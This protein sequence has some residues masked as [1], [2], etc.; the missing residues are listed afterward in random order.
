MI[1][2]KNGN[3]ETIDLEAIA[4]V[5]MRDN[6][7]WSKWKM[8]RWKK[9]D[10][11]EKKKTFFKSIFLRD[12]YLNLLLDFPHKGK[13]KKKSSSHLL[14]M[15]KIWIWLQTDLVWEIRRYIMDMVNTRVLSQT[16]K[17]KS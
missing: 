13:E 17:W 15:I 2:G 14:E 8:E 1:E 10:R 5:H 6:D 9:G 16:V 3:R 12:S 11:F 7:S 4:D